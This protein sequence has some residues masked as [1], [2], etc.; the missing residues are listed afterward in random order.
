MPSATKKKGATTCWLG[1]ELPSTCRGE[2]RVCVEVNVYKHKCKKYS[3][4][5]NSCPYLNECRIGIVN[6]TH[7]ARGA[8][9]SDL[10]KQY[11]PQVAKEQ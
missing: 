9:L 4:E 3:C 1:R 5:K 11:G 2:C 6:Q 10:Y 7:S 8:S